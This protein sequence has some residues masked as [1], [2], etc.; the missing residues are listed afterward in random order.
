L[1]ANISPLLFTEGSEPVVTEHRKG[2]E[3]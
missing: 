3:Q 2:K 1:M